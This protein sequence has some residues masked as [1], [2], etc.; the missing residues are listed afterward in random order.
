MVTEL[1]LGL[2]NRRMDP[3][4]RRHEGVKDRGP[5]KPKS[6]AGLTFPAKLRRSIRKVSVGLD[7]FVPQERRGVPHYGTQKIVD[8]V[9]RPALSEQHPAEKEPASHSARLRSVAPPFRLAS[10]LARWVACGFSG[11]VLIWNAGVVERHCWRRAAI[12]EGGSGVS[13]RRIVSRVLRRA[14]RAL[15]GKCERV[16]RKE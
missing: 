16:S 5:G 8:F 2:K 15:G 10:A 13:V 1:L 3:R 4:P 11:A 6:V 14:A 7:F 12:L 9:S